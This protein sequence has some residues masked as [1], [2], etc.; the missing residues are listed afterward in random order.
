MKMLNP[1]ITVTLFLGFLFLVGLY[2]QVW[3]VCFTVIIIML[4]LVWEEHLLD[5]LLHRKHGVVETY[6]WSVRTLW[7]VL[8]SASTIS[9]WV[10]LWLALPL[11]FL[12]VLT[13]FPKTLLYQT[14]GR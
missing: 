1:R 8:F 10:S 14:N 11:P 13:M 9:A 6:V 12:A 2:S 5:R 4:L 7:L 3:S